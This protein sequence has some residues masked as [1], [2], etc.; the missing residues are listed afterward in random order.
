M[1]GTKLRAEGLIVLIGVLILITILLLVLKT[2]PERP[3]RYLN[4]QLN[5]QRHLVEKFGFGSLIT[6]LN[7]LGVLSNAIKGWDTLGDYV[8]AVKDLADPDNLYQVQNKITNWWSGKKIEQS[9]HTHP[10]TI[11]ININPTQRSK[12]SS[13]IYE[14]KVIV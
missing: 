3:Y 11:F 1:I 12:T 7:S 13:Q 5:E 9:A 4:A 2:T 8:P 10:H 6:G 14:C